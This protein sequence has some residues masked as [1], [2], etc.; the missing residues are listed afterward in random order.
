MEA[1]GMSAGEGGGRKVDQRLPSPSWRCKERGEEGGRG[2]PD[3]PVPDASFG[4]CLPQML[5]NDLSPMENHHV[6]ASLTVLR[7][8]DN[9]FLS[10]LSRKVWERV[11]NCG[12][13]VSG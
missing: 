5:Y 7:Q 13:W 6:S 8:E 9:D 2:H 4:S 10:H 12:Y 11:D 1:G 3:Q